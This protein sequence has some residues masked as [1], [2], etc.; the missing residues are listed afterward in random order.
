MAVAGRTEF[1]DRLGELPLAGEGPYA[2]QAYC[3]AL[4]TFGTSAEADLLVA[5]LD[6]YLPR[7]DPGRT[8][9]TTDRR[10]AQQGEL[11]GGEELTDRSHALSGGGWQASPP[12]R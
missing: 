12:G 4:V 9:A 5:S 3:V 6:H 7:P 2:G 8:L 1:R 10:T 11:P